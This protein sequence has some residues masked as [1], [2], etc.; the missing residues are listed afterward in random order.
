MALNLPSQKSSHLLRR[1]VLLLAIQF[2]FLA[3]TTKF[4]AFFL[5]GMS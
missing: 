4:D 3:Q 2:D 5:L 1:A